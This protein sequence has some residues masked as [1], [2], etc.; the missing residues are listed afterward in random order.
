[1][2]QLVINSPALKTPTTMLVL[3]TSKASSMVAS[4]ALYD[5]TLYAK[6]EHGAPK[7]GAP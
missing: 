1:M 3:P 6:K 2:R 7:M 4:F 5:L